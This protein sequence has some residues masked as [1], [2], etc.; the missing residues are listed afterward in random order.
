MKF[1]ASANSLIAL[2][3]STSLLPEQITV[4]LDAS[5]DFNSF[6]AS[7][8]ALSTLMSVNLFK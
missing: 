2:T 8:I 6:K 4:T 7:A 5:A 3:S 1:L